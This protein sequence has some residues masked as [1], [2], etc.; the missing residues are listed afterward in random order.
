MGFPA[1]VPDIPTQQNFDAIALPE[2]W[3]EI[4]PTGQPSPAFAANWGNY[5][6]AQFGTAAFYKDVSGRVYIK[7]LVT[8]TGTPAAGFPGDLIFTL[9]SEY[10]PDARLMFAVQSG[11]PNGI[12][13]VD[14]AVTGNVTWMTGQTA[15]QDYTSLSG[16]SFR[17]AIRT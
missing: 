8:K 7:G 10:R 17:A 9:P 16:I 3:Q 5:S 2:I 15:E 12:G 14:I 6:D 13:R 11:E 1:V 4:H